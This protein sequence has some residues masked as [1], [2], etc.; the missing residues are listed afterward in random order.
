MAQFQV[1][2]PINFATVLALRAQGEAVIRQSATDSIMMFDLNHVH[3]TDSAVLPL[4]AAWLRCGKQR[5]MTIR[6]CNVPDE[7]ARITR[8]CGLWPLLHQ[9]DSGRS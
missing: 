5:G 9:S 3:C 6:F 8:V 7:L 1:T 4:L 2:Q